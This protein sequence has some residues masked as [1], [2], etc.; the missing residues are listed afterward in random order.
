MQLKSKLLYYFQVTKLHQ[1]KHEE[2]HTELH[3]EQVSSEAAEWQQMA[4]KEK[5]YTEV[6]ETTAFNMVSNF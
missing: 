2:S 1:Q 5:T 3:T 4:R 6:S